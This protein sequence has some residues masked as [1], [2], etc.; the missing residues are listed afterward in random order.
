VTLAVPGADLV[1]D[2]RGLVCPRPVVELARALPTVPVGAV[3]AVVADDPAAAGDVPAWCRLRQQE[4]VGPRTTPDGPAFL[5]R[6]LS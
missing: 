3:L 4:Y 5:V 6:R 1:I 2:A